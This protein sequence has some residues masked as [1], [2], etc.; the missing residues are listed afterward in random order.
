VWSIPPGGRAFESGAVRQICLATI[1]EPI[2]FE[3]DSEGIRLEPVM[4]DLRLGHSVFTIV[5]RDITVKGADC[6]RESSLP[7]DHKLAHRARV[8]SLVKAAR[9]G[10]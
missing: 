10:K 7:H 5:S 1:R 9:D 8:L 4:G 2:F 6:Q 3:D